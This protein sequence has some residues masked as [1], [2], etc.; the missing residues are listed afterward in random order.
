MIVK[1]YK[2]I[3]FNK[4]NYVTVVETRGGF[5]R[6]GGIGDILAG[7]LASCYLWNAI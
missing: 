3:I 4:G 6:C 7:C 5:K 2:D 1:G